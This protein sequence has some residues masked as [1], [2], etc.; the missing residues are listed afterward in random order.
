M[1]LRITDGTTTYTLHNDTGSTSA[2]IGGATYFPTEGD[3]ETARDTIEVVFS[4]TPDNLI[5]T[6]N[7]LSRM[8]TRASQGPTGIA[9]V[10]IEY[11][12]R[13]SGIHALIWRSPIES[14]VIS[15]SSDRTLRNMSTTEAF[16]EATITL[17]RADYW[18]GAEVTIT[19][20]GLKN[21][22]ASPYNVAFHTTVDGNLPTPIKVRITNTSG[23]LSSRNI[24]LY[25]DIFASLS[26]DQHFVLSNQSSS[27][28]SSSAHTALRWLMTIPNAVV[29]KLAGQNVN[30]MA[31]F[32]TLS[33]DIYLRAGLWADVDTTV[34]AAYEPVSLG[35]EKFISD[36]KL[37]N[38]GT[39]QVPKTITGNL[40]IVV[41]ANSQVSGSGAM[42]WVQLSP[43]E[44]GVHLR[45]G[46]WANNDAIVYDGPNKAAYYETGGLKFATVYPSGGPLLMWPA[47]WNRL[48]V[49]FD[50]TTGITLTRTFNVAITVRP[51]RR[52][53]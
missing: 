15:W 16:G 29:A 24:Y 51:R 37:V 12:L 19:S 52:T 22:M 28:V 1:I 4:G 11:Q 8:I 35:G 42:L 44:G 32:S 48:H 14:A 38:L 49:L 39:V 7:N 5:S 34:F 17:T 46:D 27:W 2:G 18:E 23:A 20:N 6:F 43:A 53:V 41:T 21:G 26:T 36:R 47:T 25:A 13:D 45:V 9:P 10:W 50:E 40:F 3:G 31:A 33:P 30:V